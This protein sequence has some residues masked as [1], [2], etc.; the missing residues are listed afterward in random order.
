MAGVS[1]SVSESSGD[2]ED[3]EWRERREGEQG[4]RHKSRHRSRRRRDRRSHSDSPERVRKRK[5]DSPSRRG[6][7][8]EGGDHRDW[9]SGAAEERGQQRDERRQGSSAADPLLASLAALSHVSKSKAI[10]TLLRGSVGGS[11]TG[12]S[13]FAPSAESAEK[14][15]FPYISFL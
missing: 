7:S 11:G 9:R 3:R 8:E 4:R 2:E 13:S 14:E 12:Q 15:L 5:R 6:S 1:G 10:A